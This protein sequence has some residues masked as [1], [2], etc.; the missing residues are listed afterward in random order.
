MKITNLKFRVPKQNA[1]NLKS[2]VDI[3]F[4][5]C[6]VIH[7]AKVVEG[8]NDLIVSMPATKINKKFVDIVHPITAEF[9]KYITDEVVTKYTELKK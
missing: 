2:Y 6:L 1:G 5:D 3:T 8:K 9:R 7:N 4:N